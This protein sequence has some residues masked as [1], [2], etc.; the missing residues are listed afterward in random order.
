M[1]IFYIVKFHKI[2]PP[3]IVA[4]THSQEKA[5]EL[6]EQPETRGKDWFL[7]WTAT[8]PCKVSRAG[9]PSAGDF[10]KDIYSKR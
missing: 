6:C 1:A 3:R 9:Y 10:L 8:P 4:F 2:N 5:R 7:G